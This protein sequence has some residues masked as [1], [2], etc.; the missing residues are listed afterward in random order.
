MKMLKDLFLAE[1]AD[2]YD[3]EKRLV[4]AM[5]AMAKTATC[6]ELQKLIKSHLKETIGHVKKLE[7]VFKAF[8]AK[9]QART[10]EATI[11]LLREGAEIAADFKKS[12]ALNAAL[13][14]V[15]QKIEHYEIVSYGCLREWSA[16]LGNKNATASLQEIL[17]EE[18]AANRSLIDLAR[19][20]SNK[21]ALG[22]CA[23]TCA[24]NGKATKT[25][26]RRPVLV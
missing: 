24:R 23:D 1:L 6:K 8:G 12:P 10:C 2:R 25:P 9:V 19:W 17:D 26:N 22:E 11:G 15:A 4:R 7:T 21:E 5:P 3:S 20:R 14:S 18:K 16:V 13:I